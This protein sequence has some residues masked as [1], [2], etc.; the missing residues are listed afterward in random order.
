MCYQGTEQKERAAPQMRHIFLTVCR[1]Q[2]FKDKSWEFSFNTVNWV[3]AFYMKIKHKNSITN[4]TCLR[5]RLQSSNSHYY[6]HFLPFVMAKHCWYCWYWKCNNRIVLYA[7]LWFSVIA[8]TSLTQCVFACTFVHNC[9]LPACSSVC[10]DTWLSF[11]YIQQI[12]CCVITD[13]CD[14]T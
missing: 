8:F 5:K 2:D 10:L 11:P 7:P 6:C 14:A 3:R 4:L 12:W 9:C 1:G 13:V